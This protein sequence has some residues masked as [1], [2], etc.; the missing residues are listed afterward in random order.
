MDIMHDSDKGSASVGQ[1]SDAS[2]SEERLM[3]VCSP[4][5]K[6]ESKA[7]VGCVVDPTGLNRLSD[8]FTPLKVWNQH[9]V[10]ESQ[11]IENIDVNTIHGKGSRY[12]GICLQP[13]TSNWGSSRFGKHHM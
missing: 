10:L 8:S 5:C 12:L 3:N 2:K 6:G 13:M 11:V 4:V 7:K 9:F 1:V